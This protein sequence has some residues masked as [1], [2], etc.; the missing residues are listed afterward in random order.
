MVMADGVDRW[1]WLMAM[2]DGGWRQRGMRQR[3]RRLFCVRLKV[4]LIQSY[5]IFGYRLVD[6]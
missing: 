5:Q 3:G 1:R 2:A 4:R 6:S